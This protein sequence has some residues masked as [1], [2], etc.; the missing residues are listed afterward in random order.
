M[1]HS[2]VDG[3]RDNNE[4]YRSFLS[5]AAEQLSVLR[6]YCIIAYTFYLVYVIGRC[7]PHYVDPHH[8]QNN[9]F[10]STVTYTEPSQSTITKHL[11]GSGHGLAYV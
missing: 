10:P 6:S 7:T 9:E 8:D 11:S 3:K 4:Y 5:A 2:S 1:L